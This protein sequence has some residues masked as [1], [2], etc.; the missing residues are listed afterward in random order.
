MLY[1]L[2]AGGVIWGSAQW[3]PRLALDLEGG[4]E[5]ILKAI[6]QPGQE[7]AITPATID[8]AI[9]II[10]KRVDGSGV[11]EAEVF[12][13]GQDSIVVT[14]PGKNIDEA[15]RQAIKKSAA[16]EFQPG[17]S[18][19]A[20]L[21]RPS[22]RRPGLRPA[23]PRPAPRPPP[24]VGR[25]RIPRRARREAPAVAVCRLRPLPPRPVAPNRPARPEPIRA[26]WRARTAVPG[27]VPRRVRA[28]PVT[29][30]DR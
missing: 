5:L 1:G 15:T 19:R 14:L 17:S 6:P 11:A 29:W 23:R 27:P 13:S 21:S 9:K 22:R 16:L 18:S 2:I 30:P 28:T 24:A 12:R 4:T 8:E 7:G 26:V 20:R 25:R 10:R 3:T